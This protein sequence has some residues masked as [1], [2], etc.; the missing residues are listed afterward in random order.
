MDAFWASIVEPLLTAV[1]PEVVVEVGTDRG[2]TALPLLAWARRSG[3]VVHLIDPAPSIDTDAIS[4]EFAGVVHVHREMSVEALPRLGQIDVAL[5]D[6]DHNWY[7][8]SRELQLL[9]SCNTRDSVPPIVVLHDLDWPYGRRDLYYDPDRIPD[10]AR[11]PF[12]ARGMAPGSDVLVDGGFNDGLFN[13]T[14]EGG[15]RNGVRTAVEDFLATVDDCVFLDLPGFHGLGIVLPAG[16]A[17]RPE[18]VHQ[19]ERL[20]STP[21]MAGLARD[22]ERNRVETEWRRRQTA[23]ALSGARAA[24]DT[25]EARTDELEKEKR[26]IARAREIARSDLSEAERRAEILELRLVDAVQ[27][28]RNLEEQVQEAR[29]GASDVRLEEL[30]RRADLEAQRAAAV[31]AAGQLGQELDVAHASLR[32]KELDHFALCQLVSELRA[33]L[34]AIRGSRDRLD[35]NLRGRNAQLRELLSRQVEQE[36]RSRSAPAPGETCE[37]TTEIEHVLRHV[38]HPA[39]KRWATGRLALDRLRGRLDDVGDRLTEEQRLRQSAEETAAELRAALEA[40]RSAGERLR[41]DV[42]ADRE[43]LAVLAHDLSRSRSWRYGHAFFSLMRRLAFR[44][45]IGRSAVEKV[46]E[47]VEGD[48]RALAAAK[49]GV[50]E[51]PPPGRSS[52]ATWRAPA[53]SSDLD[54]TLEALLR[55]PVPTVVIPV[56]NAADDLERCLHS[57]ERHTTTEARLLLIDDAST[58]PRVSTILARYQ[59]RPFI[60]ILRNVHNHGF[61]R[62]VNIGVD[63]CDG[64]V[65][66]LNSDTEVGPRWLELLRDAAYRD[67]RIG[68]V[69]PI[70]NNAGAFSVPHVG[71][72]NP[73]PPGLTRSESARF[74]M[75]AGTGKTPDTPTGNGFCLYLKRAMLT[76]VGGF[77]AQSFPRGYGEE[78]D[79]CMRACEQG[80]RHVVDDRV[81]VFHVRSASFGP[82]KQDLIAAGRK[83]VD[84]R[85]PGYTDAVRAF[86][87]GP[88]MRAVRNNVAWTRSRLRPHDAVRPRILFVLHD[89]RGGTPQTNL[90]LMRTLEA[91]YQPLT[92]TSDGRILRLHMLSGGELTLIESQPLSRPWTAT[93]FSDG[94]YREAVT[95]MLRDHAIEIVHV[96]HLFKQPLDLPEIAQTLGIP[97]ILSVHDFYL[98]CPTVHLVDDR[99]DHC[100]AVCTEGDGECVPPSSMLRGLPQ[101]KH[102]WVNVWRDEMRARVVS[103]ADAMV[104]TSP[105]A[106]DIHGRVFPEFE[107]RFDVIEH[108]RDLPP[109][110]SSSPSLAPGERLRVLV[111]G[112]VDEH[113][114]GQVLRELVAQDREAQRLE[115]HFLG[116]TSEAYAGLGVQHGSYERSEFAEKV[117]QI[118]PH[119]TAILSI[120]PETYCHTLSEAWSAGVPVVTTELGATGERVRQHGGGILVPPADGPATYAALIDLADDPQALRALG[121]AVPETGF[122]TLPAMALDYDHLYRQTLAAR[123]PFRR[124]S[125]RTRDAGVMK[126]AA[127]APGRPGMAPGSTYVRVYNRLGHPD[128]SWRLGVSY[129]E[130]PVR[131]LRADVVLVQRTA[132]APGKAEPLID[133]LRRTDVPLVVELDDDLLSFDSD[134]PEYGPHVASLTQLVQAAALVTVSTESLRE[135]LGDIASAT[136]VPN[137]LHDRM[138]TA[139]VETERSDRGASGP[140]RLLYAGTRTHAEDLAILREAVLRV[141][142]E[143]GVEIELEVIGGERPGPGQD[144]YRRLDVPKGDHVYP[145]FVRWLRSNASRWDMAAA[146]LVDSSVNRAKSDLKFLEYSALGLPGIYSAGAAYD[147]CADADRAIVVPESPDAWSGAILKLAQDA[148]RRSEMAQRAREHVLA[149][150]MISVDASYYLD[151]LTGL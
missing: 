7:T 101:L 32:R 102:R 12:A 72:V 75:Q 94:P 45:P 85:H 59:G 33:E 21:V 50:A 29:S 18:V 114:G 55:A 108:G 28:A 15:A 95:R 131:G 116:H 124:S 105:Y 40:E 144:W 51:L 65:V 19:I 6:G 140:L 11:H 83:V 111:P 145:R 143:G 96:R 103:Q 25:A 52:A 27:R 142:D 84:E 48:L 93:C 35:R 128:I 8:V 88:E 16:R 133:E 106:R 44:P 54:D 122:R 69:T 149:H 1:G 99:G 113:K 36:Q 20:R 87:D 56:Y 86:V 117:R 110:T 73:L 4:S 53:A 134:D 62:T 137:M 41:R 47:I 23:Q 63:S 126:V 104:T 37:P 139:P 22:L 91:S 82:E 80:W 2:A 77:D 67:P 68:T 70:S 78:N 46:I 9:F 112:N 60:R 136:V 10:T 38:P 130:D 31:D 64:D 127:L 81:F 150:R 58:D 57:V 146:P 3:A 34:R 98:T 132:V 90:D 118:K 129:P 24:R 13:A 100:G 92:L 97:V 74:A 79:L 26:N 147:R 76:E 71:K 14:R 89:G 125:R 5:I 151:L 119:V 42:E 61:T 66:L 123:S 30:G 39:I 49:P 17:T 43:R 121:D 148:D 138:W 115:L 120:W 107:G 135:R 109:P 141:R